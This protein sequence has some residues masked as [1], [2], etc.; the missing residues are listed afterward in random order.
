[1]SNAWRA[2]G[3][4]MGANMQALSFLLLG[5]FLGKFLDE[6]YEQSWNWSY[7]LIGFGLV[8]AIYGYYVVV[9]KLLDIEKRE[10][11]DVKGNRV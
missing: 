3:F 9:K 5:Y 11:A 2:L 1:M 8:L 6:H 10:A 7:W 4:I